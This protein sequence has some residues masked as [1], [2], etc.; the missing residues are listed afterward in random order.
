MSK[1]FDGKSILVTGAASGIGRATALAFGAEGGRVTVVDRSDKDGEA[2]AKAIR[3][4]GGAAIFF[5]ADVSKAADCRAMVEAAVAAHGGLACAFN[6]AGI[7]RHGYLTA[8]IEES[9]WNE[10]IAVNLNGVFLSMKYEIPE[11]LKHGGGAIVN[12]ASVG[13]VVGNPG[14]GAYCAAKHGVI[15][16]TKVAALEYVA[17]GVRINALCPGGTAT[18]MLKNWF[19]EPGVE[20]H[21]KALH[22][23]GRWADPSEQAKAVLFLCS[24]DA[25]YMAG[26][27]LIVDGAMTAQ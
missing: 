11:M 22:P 26:H 23:I 25:S 24:D 6:N 18:P 20:E 14:L 13:G 7:E 17:Q 21:V 16:I 4:S 27:S 19:Q 15:G 8:D 9:S 1:R 10:V 2:A 12:T 3:D 5:K